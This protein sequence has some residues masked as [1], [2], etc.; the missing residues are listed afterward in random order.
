VSVTVTDNLSCGQCREQFE[1][2][3]SDARFC[4]SACRQKAY[5]RRVSARGSG[6]T[7]VHMRGGE[8]PFRL[9]AETRQALRRAIDRGRRELLEVR[10]AAAANREL[11]ADEAV[12]A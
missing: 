1:P 5:R 2:A 10:E 11:F 3:R 9:T 4:S 12:R 7:R 8:E 6:P